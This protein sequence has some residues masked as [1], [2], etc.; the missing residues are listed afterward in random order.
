VQSTFERPP[1]QHTPA[2]IAHPDLLTTPPALGGP[3]V[4]RSLTLAYAASLLI[5]ALVALASAVALTRAAGDLYADSSSVLVS[6]GADA[7]SLLLMPLLLSAM[8]GAY[9]GRLLGLLLWPGTLF[10]TLYG[11]LPYAIS[12]SATW[13]L[14]VDVAL[15]TLSTFTLVGVLVAID[16]SAVRTRLRRTPVVWVG[17]ALTAIGLF[18][19]AGLAA[20]SAATLA[21]AGARGH[22]VADW[23]MG[24]PALVL[25]GVLLLRR[26][27]LGYVVAAGLLLVSALGGVVFAL[28]ATVDNLLSGP[29]T[30]PA[31]IIVHLVI[32]P[33][34]AAL[35]AVFFRDAG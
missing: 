20:N 5:A 18:A 28:A 3:P 8:W 34:S 13:L 25:G 31:T 22:W 30:E 7:A 11:Y 23:T 2:A 12:A 6:R 4:T 24:T 21:E 19:Y 35:L 29:W 1:D 14:F 16:G 10:Y 32:S 26:V 33:F 17:S 27:R 9:R 15:V